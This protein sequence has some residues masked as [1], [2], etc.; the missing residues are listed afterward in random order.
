MDRE[1]PPLDN[2]D[3]LLCLF[4]FPEPRATVVLT[5]VPSS[6]TIAMYRAEQSPEQKLRDSGLEYAEAL[7]SGS[8]GH[9][10]ARQVGGTGLT[11]V[12]G[13]ILRSLK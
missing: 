7:G 5:L 8:L 4:L 12:E 6:A 11:E 13:L 2:L 1:Q 9:V 3:S 10:S